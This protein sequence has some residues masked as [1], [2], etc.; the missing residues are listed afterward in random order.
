M[1]SETQGMENRSDILEL[2]TVNR[3]TNMQSS[4]QNDIDALDSV[5]TSSHLIN[6]E[7]SEK[8]WTSYLASPLK[9]PF[10]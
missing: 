8:S 2:A 3:I 7:D 5:S 1:W 6:L 9:Y 4:S 10:R